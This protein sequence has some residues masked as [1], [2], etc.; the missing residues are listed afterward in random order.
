MKL[1]I[2]PRWCHIWSRSHLLQGPSFFGTIYLVPN[3]ENKSNPRLHHPSQIV[4]ATCVTHTSLSK[5]QTVAIDPPCLGKQAGILRV[6]LCF[7]YLFAEAADTGHLEQILGELKGKAGNQLWACLGA[8]KWGP[9]MMCFFCCTKP[10]V[11]GCFW[12]P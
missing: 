7:F 4:N 3:S 10:K 12:F 6:V 9:G 11:N 2:D 8:M 1:S 5:K